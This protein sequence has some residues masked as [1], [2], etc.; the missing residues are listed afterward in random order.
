M[1]GTCDPDPVTKVS[2]TGYFWVVEIPGFVRFG[3]VA[4][5]IT[6]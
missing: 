3:L 2:P 4:A 1:A 5:N 6:P